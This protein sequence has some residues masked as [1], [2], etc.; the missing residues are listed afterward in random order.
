M[1][2][3]LRLGQFRIHWG[4]GP[5]LRSRQ[6]G[7]AAAGP[8]LRIPS[9]SPCTSFPASRPSSPFEALAHSQLVPSPPPAWAGRLS[10]PGKDPA[11]GPRRGPA[12]AR[13]R[14][15]CIDNPRRAAFVQ[16]AVRV[17]QHIFVEIYTAGV[18]HCKLIPKKLLAYRGVN[19]GIQL[20]CPSEAFDQ[21]DRPARPKIQNNRSGLGQ[22]PSRQQLQHSEPK[23]P[24]QQKWPP[25]RNC[26][27]S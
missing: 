7:H 21:L 23:I 26:D 8:G 18:V 6:P 17:C 27:D 1:L 15:A 19:G 25:P 22:R 3:V 11:K 24:K 5:G 10:N 4:H 14:L 9:G 20:V 12:A 13:P 2:R 16:A